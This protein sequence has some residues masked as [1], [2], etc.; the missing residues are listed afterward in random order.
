MRDLEDAGDAQATSRTASL[1][2]EVAQLRRRDRAQLDEISQLHAALEAAEK[3]TGTGAGAGGLG[4]STSGLPT[5]PR[6][7]V[8]ATRS[9][10]SKAARAEYASAHKLTTSLEFVSRRPF[11][12]PSCTASE[13]SSCGASRGVGDDD[14]G[15]GGGRGLGGSPAVVTSPQ[16]APCPETA[17]AAAQAELAVSEAFFLMDTNDDGVLTR[18]EVI[19]SGV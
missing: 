15:E 7:A 2:A 10:P 11:M 14:G 9:P 6:V 17:S 13:P 4:S 16:V 12:G 18:I 5:A 19:A 8:A 1:D 3:G